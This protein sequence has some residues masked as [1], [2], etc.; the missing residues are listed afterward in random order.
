MKIKAPAKV[1]L[2]LEVLKRRDDGYHE[3]R[4]I[5]QSID[6]CDELELEEGKELEFSCDRQELN[7]EDNLAVRACRLLQ[8]K[9]SITKEARIKLKKLIPVAAGLGG[10]SSDAAAVLKGLNTLWGLDLSTDRLME[11]AAEL[12]SDV[13]FFILGGTALARS[14]GEIIKPLPSPGEYWFVLLMPPVDTFADKTSRMYRNLTEANYTKGE[15]T[16]SLASRIKA[17]GEIEQSLLYNVF[18]E[19]AYGIYPQLSLFR[20][21]LAEEAGTDKVHLAGSGPCIYVILK[22]EARAKHTRLSLMKKKYT[23]YLS[24]LLARTVLE[25]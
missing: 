19:V 23:V 4:S 13:P 8:K 5:L 17:G 9:A 12:G 21:L 7:N 6:L 10:G 14:R 16:Q 22:D 25:L 2:T 18:D 24:K 1:N 20:K 15:F 11:I 3:I